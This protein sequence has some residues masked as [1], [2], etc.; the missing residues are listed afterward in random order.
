MTYNKY[1]TPIAAFVTFMVLTITNLISAI[2]HI[3]YESYW[4]FAYTSCCYLFCLFVA[5]Q[6]AY[7]MIEDSLNV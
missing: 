3:T 6:H 5:S 7:N 2:I 4:M 1:W